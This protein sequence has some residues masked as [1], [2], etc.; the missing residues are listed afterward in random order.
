MKGENEMK[1]PDF[2]ADLN[3]RLFQDATETRY[4]VDTQNNIID[5]SGNSLMYSGYVQNSEMYT[6][7]GQ[8]LGT[9]ENEYEEYDEFDE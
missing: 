7:S 6:N 3:G 1:R 5:T 9:L 4:I 8:Y 2:Q